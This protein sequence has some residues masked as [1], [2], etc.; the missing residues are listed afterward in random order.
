ML[1]PMFAI[2]L[3]SDGVEKWKTH[4]HFA[5]HPL[6]V[7]FSRTFRLNFNGLTKRALTPLTNR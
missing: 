7:F 4:H 2:L 6:V 1:V 3:E 5:E